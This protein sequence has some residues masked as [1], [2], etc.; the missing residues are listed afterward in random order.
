MQL[1]LTEALTGF[2]KTITHLDGRILSINVEPGVV[3]RHDAVK[4]IQG[5]GMPFH[6]NPF[7]KGRLFLHFKVAFPTS[8][9]PEVVNVLK[10]VLPKV[11]TPMLTGEEE[12]CDMKE[13]DLS[14]FGQSGEAHRRDATGEDEEDERGGQRVQ[15]GQ[16]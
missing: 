13:V 9:T 14:Q 3:T 11:P 8:L 15:C 1:N 16:A 6:G 7:T 4:M 10:T 5:E 2:T 12:E